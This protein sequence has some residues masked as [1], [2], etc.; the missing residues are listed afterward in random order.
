VNVIEGADTRLAR[1]AV[2]DAFNILADLGIASAVVD[3]KGRR[4]T[5]LWEFHERF[6]DPSDVRD[7]MSWNGRSD[8]IW[9]GDYENE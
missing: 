8:D 7:V 5:T 4:L 1:E 2:Q 3:P 6:G 9:L